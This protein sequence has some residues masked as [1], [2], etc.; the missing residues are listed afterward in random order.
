MS[1]SSIWWIALLKSSIS[2]WFFVY[3]FTVVLSLIEKKILKFLI[4]IMD[5]SVSP[6]ISVGFCFTLKRHSQM[7]THLGLLRT[8]GELTSLLL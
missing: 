2:L 7:H 6:L 1:V 8:V 3:L 4:I 5:L